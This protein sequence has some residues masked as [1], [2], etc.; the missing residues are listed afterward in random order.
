[1]GILKPFSRTLVPVSPDQ[2]PNGC[3][4]IHRGGGV[5]SSTLPIS[6]PQK[7]VAEISQVVLNAFKSAT[8]S[9]L[10]LNDLHIHYSGLRILARELRGGALIFLTPHQ[11]NF[12]HPKLPSA[13]SYKNIDEFILHLET[14]IECWK[15]FNHYLNLA[16][17]KKFTP[18]DLMHYIYAVIYS[19][20][21]REKFAA[22][23]KIDFPRIPF[24]TDFNLFLEIAEMGKQLTELHLLNHKSLNKPITR[25]HGK[26]DDR[27]EKVKYDAE[28]QRVTLNDKNYFDGIS[29]EVWNYQIGGYKVMDKYLKPRVGRQMEDPAHYCKMATAIARTIE[30]QVQVDPLF[31]R[32]EK[33]TIQ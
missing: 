31:K 1:M 6:Y 5:I 30:I 29:P 27:I 32:V 11:P 10:P 2:L 16:R 21:Y 26:G 20:A 33:R 8:D 12:T 22:F 28:S 15:Q 18:E 13:M 19:N 25:Y 9:N 17:D 14:H 23:L 24:T 4:A 7:L 3:F